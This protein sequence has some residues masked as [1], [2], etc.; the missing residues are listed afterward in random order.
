MWV[1]KHLGEKIKKYKHTQEGCMIP[2]THKKCMC[3]LRESVFRGEPDLAFFSASEFVGSGLSSVLLREAIL[4]AFQTDAAFA[5]PQTMF[6]ELSEV[7]SSHEAAVF[8]QRIAALPK[9]GVVLMTDLVASYAI[10]VELPPAV[11]FAPPYYISVATVLCQA[12]ING[13]HMSLTD[14]RAAADRAA[15]ARQLLEAANSRAEVERLA[16]VAEEQAAQGYAAMLRAVVIAAAFCFIREPDQ[17]WN[18]LLS[19]SVP[20]WQELHRAVFDPTQPW[21]RARFI[22][23]TCIVHIFRGPAADIPLP[24]LPQPAARMSTFPAWALPSS[25][26]QTFFAFHGRLAPRPTDEWVAATNVGE[27]Y[28]QLF[29]EFDGGNTGLYQEIF[30]RNDQSLSPQRR[31]VHD[32]AFKLPT[33][34]AIPAAYLSAV[35]PVIPE[36]GAAGTRVFGVLPSI[37]GQVNTA[38]AR[39]LGWRL[40]EGSVA[41]VDLPNASH[42]ASKNADLAWLLAVIDPQHFLFT[43]CEVR[44]VGTNKN[45]LAVQYPRGKI[46]AAEQALASAETRFRLL[47]VWLVCAIWGFSLPVLESI[48]FSPQAMWIDV[49][50]GAEWNVFA[51]MRFGK[52]IAHEFQANLGRYVPRTAEE[53]LMVK[54]YSEI[55]N[56]FLI[57]D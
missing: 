52:R 27:L 26:L 30:A 5:M 42:V 2:N 36:P 17:L 13:L 33:P 41:L 10:S 57:N 35:I 39:E 19:F 12:L 34:Y 21:G 43:P 31:L 20:N 6:A 44:C 29:S 22:I 9:A 54:H 25:A 23:I 38:Q 50:T 48:H 15:E 53:P 45:M 40:L 55:L 28:H 11:W 51:Y 14:M 18:V 3:L 49:P 47:G 1:G 8:L 24:R 16:H 46:L 37:A 7:W 4:L 32:P 56:N